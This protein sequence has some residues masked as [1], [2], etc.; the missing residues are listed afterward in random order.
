MSC[1][2]LQTAGSRQRIPIPPRVGGLSTDKSIKGRQTGLE[3]L[4]KEEVGR[5]LLF[6]Q[7]LQCQLSHIT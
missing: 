6:L 5:L 1:D 2:A 7:H 4:D 3:G